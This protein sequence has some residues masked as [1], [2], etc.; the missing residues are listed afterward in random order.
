VSAG[1]PISLTVTADDASGH[2]ATDYRG[3]AH[4]TS[5][6]AAATLPANYAFTAADA[7]VHTFSGVVLRTAGSRL[8][9]ATD[10]VTGSLTTTFPV[11]VAAAGATQFSVV[12]SVPSPTAG[13]PFGVTVTAEDAQGHT[14]A[15]YGGTVHFSS[16]DPRATLPA[17]YTFTA[18]DH[19]VHTFSGVVFR[20]AGGPTLTATG[21]PVGT[22]TE[23]PIPTANSGPAGITAGPDGNLW[24]TENGG[25][26]VGIITPA[27][28][29]SETSPL[30][31][32]GSGPAGIT[33]GPDGNLWFTE[34]TGNRVAKLTTGAVLSEASL[35]SS[36]SG[37]AGITAGPDGNLWFTEFTGNRLG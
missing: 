37:P 16:S 28:A 13:T 33:A 17:D 19:G 23:I 7:G 1:T 9:T 22:V 15:D 34:F 35:P 14:V 36:G 32:S 20:S 6:D 29:V 10:T 8:V 24:F 21:D 30:P 31:S 11:T 18:A 4:F 25:N 12:P 26:K 27:G 5:S 2:T 3:T